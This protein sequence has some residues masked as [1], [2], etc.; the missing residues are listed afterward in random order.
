MENNK[1]KKFRYF[2]NRQRISPKIYDY[3]YILLLKSCVKKYQM[4]L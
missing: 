2:I 3:S 4:A 1:I